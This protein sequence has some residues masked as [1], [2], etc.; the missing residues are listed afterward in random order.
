M[1]EGLKKEAFSKRDIGTP[2]IKSQKRILE[3]NLIK[4]LGKELLWKMIVKRKKKIHKRK[5]PKCS[6]KRHPEKNPVKLK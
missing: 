6:Q 2:K 1:W 3:E 4:S 5:T